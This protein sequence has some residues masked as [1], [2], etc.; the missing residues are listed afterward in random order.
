LEADFVFAGA[1]AE[2]NCVVNN[3]P[4][5]YPESIGS[6]KVAY[7]RALISFLAQSIECGSE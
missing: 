7:R 1:D 5:T 4:L 3:R 2:E 6:V